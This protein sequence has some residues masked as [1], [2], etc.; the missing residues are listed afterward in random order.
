[1]LEQYQKQ[2]RNN[3][4]QFVLINKEGTVIESDQQFLAIEAGTS[5]YDI[6]P[7]FECLPA[8]VDSD[9]KEISFFCVHLPIEE[10]FFVVD[11]KFL[12]KKEHVLLIIDDFTEHYHSYQNV[13]QTRNESVIKSE[14]TII[15]NR[16][17]EE[18]ERFKNNFIQNFSHELRNPL[19]SIMAIVAILGDTALTDEQTKMLDFL[20]ESNTNLRLMLEDTLSIG[21]IDSG[22]LK[23]Q[24][25]EFDLHSLFKLMEFTYKAKA[26]K[27]GLQFLCRFDDKIPQ[28]VIGDRLR[29][30]QVITNL[31]DNAIKYTHTGSVSFNVLLNLKRA[32]TVGLHF[33]VIDTGEGIAAEDKEQIFE[34]FNQIATGKKTNGT[35]LG[36]TIVKKLL[37]LMGS[38]IVLQLHQD[39]GTTFYFD[40]L[41]KYPL[42]PENDR[43]LQ[44]NTKT[45][46]SESSN[47]PKYKILLVE[48]DEHVQATLFKMLLKTNRFQIN[49]AYDGA[50]VFQEVVNN[51]YDLI[52]M[53]VNLPNLNGI[54][55]TKL[56]RDFPF[57]NIKKIPIIGLTAN[58][59][60]DQINQCLKAGMQ[61]VLT[62]PFEQEEFLKVI[63]KTLK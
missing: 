13:A 35:G 14:L 8:I 55:I 28:Y 26:Q 43:S 61:K 44:E 15:K 24:A 33:E 37:A 27:K 16:E 56:I 46:K 10:N 20:K 4:R 57:K 34:G 40:M 22:K 5:I 45:I 7:F 63:Y 32:N 3:K 38:K 1:M 60:K 29:L 18:R 12:V 31:L 2:Y 58:V 53:D 54:Q 30:F 6:H 17:L 42:F 51:N 62:K 52:V 25:N 59:Y 19:T 47:Q 36:L 23:I 21:M 9:E 11:I 50:F 48:D 39:K 41:F 49:L